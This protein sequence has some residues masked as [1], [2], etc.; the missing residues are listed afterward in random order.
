MGLDRNPE[1]ISRI[2]EVLT[3]LDITKKENRIIF[4]LYM[5]VVLKK[6]AIGHSLTLL[7]EIMHCACNLHTYT[8]LLGDK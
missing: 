1:A 8:N 7:L 4:L 5:Y 2:I 6:I 3:L